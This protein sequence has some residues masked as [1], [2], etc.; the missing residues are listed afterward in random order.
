MRKEHLRIVWNKTDSGLRDEEQVYHLPLGDY[1]SVTKVLSGMNDFLWVHI[2]KIRDGVDNLANVSAEGGDVDAWVQDMEGVWE[3]ATLPADT[4]LRDGEY[5]SKFGLRY[6]KEAADRGTAVHCLFE[7]YGQGLRADV[8]EAREL[9]GW[10]VMENGL[11]CNTVEL[12]QYYTSALRWLDRY[13]PDFRLQEVVVCNPT[14]GYAGRC[15]V[16]EVVIEDDSFIADIKSSDS[17]KRSWLMQLAA[18]RAASV[19]YIIEEVEGGGVKASS[20]LDFSPATYQNMNGLIIMCTPDKCGHR[21]VPNETMQEYYEVFK[22]SLASFKGMSL[23]MP[24]TRA[25]WVHSDKK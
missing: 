16:R 7:A 11:R 1:P 15:D 12:S 17:L 13:Q 20:Q 21:A 8:S 9:A 14:D 10:I 19:G 24:D 2:A 25:K 6:M 18:Y 5:I 23:K 4:V 22:H 3:L